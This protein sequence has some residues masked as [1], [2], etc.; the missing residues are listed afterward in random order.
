MGGWKPNGTGNRESEESGMDYIKVPREY[1]AIPFWSWNEC[2]QP[3]ETARQ[4]NLMDQAGLGGFFMHARGGL[5]TEYMGEEWFDNVTRAVEEGNKLGMRAW[6]YDE[7][8]WPSGFGNG[9]VN[10]KGLDY[11]Q[12]YLRYEKSE[13][14]HTER[15]ICNKDGYHFYF[16]VNPFYADTLNPEAT[17]VFLDEIYA[18]YYEKYGNT[19]EGFFTDEPQISRNGI[20]WSVVLPDAYRE[21]YRENLFDVLIELFENTGDYKH[22]RVKFWKLVTELFSKNF[23]KKIY[24][25]CDERG[26]KLTGHLVLEE[27]L[28]SQLVSNGA[29]MPHY[30]YFHIPG[31]D[32]LGRHMSTDQGFIQLGSVAQQLGKRQVLT[33]SFALCGHNVSYNELKGILEWQMVRGINL[34]CP[35]LEGYSLR[36]LRKRDYPPAMYYQQP[37]WKK[38]DKFIEAM[39]RVGMILSEARVDCHTLVLHPQT[40]AWSV[41]NCGKNEGL[42]ELSDAFRALLKTLD[43]KHVIFHLGDEILMERHG[44]VEGKELIIGQMRYDRIILPQDEILLENTKKLLTEYVR[45]G[46]VILKAEDIEADPVIDN[47]EITYTRRISEDGIIHYFVNSTT[48]TQRAH[49]ARGS[50]VIDLFTGE[51]SEFDGEHTFEPFGSLLLLEDG[52][53]RTESAKVGKK[54]LSVDGKWEIVGGDDNVLTLDYCDYYFDGELQEKNGYVLNIQGRACKL[55]RPIE[56]RQ[57][58]RVNIRAVPERLFLVCETPEIFEIQVNGT[59]IDKTDCGMYR[60][61]AFRMIDLVKYVKQGENVITFLCHYKQPDS[62]YENLKKAA[63]FESEKNKITYETE[64]EAIYL[65]GDFSV[66]TDGT[67]EQLERDAVRYR[68]SFAIDR[69]VKEVFAA[70]LEQQG[71]PFF[72]GEITLAKTFELEDAERVLQFKKFGVNILE[73]TVNGKKYEHLWGEPAMDIS[74]A[75]QVGTNRVELTLTNNLR[76]LLGPHHLQAG[77]SYSVGPTI[78]YKEACIWN[79]KGSDAVP[80]D[81]DYCFTEFGLK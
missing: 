64:F 43:R 3:D 6:A 25:W 57:D 44:R 75:L 21:A 32:W 51:L 34:L 58:Y 63:I 19:F 20:P 36:G 69:P 33:E 2:L 60:D 18:P 8:G 61:I 65:L 16:D 78:F 17:Q 41:F 46:G 49:I 9:I 70:N 55:E 54:P 76:N 77:E 5:Q 37:W 53:A 80:W 47:P 35:H 4:V 22:T 42:N 68:G 29:V 10:G 50:K 39:G 52:S 11:Q 48:K 23:M 45:N 71:Y 12:K 7:N 14:K 72:C 79:P 15:T 30:E 24:D 59:T 1:R 13:E 40:A 73:V 74:D 66:A 56:V 31:V 27:S 62:L 67:F 38:Y 28:L 26:L 81:D